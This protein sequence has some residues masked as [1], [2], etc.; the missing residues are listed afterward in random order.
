MARKFF[1]LMYAMKEHPETFRERGFKALERP[2]Q[3]YPGGYRDPDAHQLLYPG[4]V[5]EAEELMLQRPHEMGG[6]VE[7]KL[8]GKMILEI[9]EEVPD[10]TK[11]EWT[12]RDEPSRIAGINISE[13]ELARIEGEEEAAS[14]MLA[15]LPPVAAG[16]PASVAA[17]A[18]PPAVR[19]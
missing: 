19:S 11:E 1:R 14:S 10:A 3:V 7:R 17:A 4:D 13:Q 16:Q 12:Q 9:V 5:F 18:R 15:P 8:D 6:W 2:N